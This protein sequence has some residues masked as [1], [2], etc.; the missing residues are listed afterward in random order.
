MKL[1][2]LDGGGDCMWCSERIEVS[3]ERSQWLLS[4]LA[5][6]FQGCFACWKGWLVSCFDV[7][8]WRLVG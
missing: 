3:S 1:G 4:T 8:E 7:P 6:L 5:G 2:M